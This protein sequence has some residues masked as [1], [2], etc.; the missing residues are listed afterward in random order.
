ML[1][2]KNPWVIIGVLT[3]VLFGGAI[4]LSQ[5]GSS[6]SNEGVERLQ[7]IAG[8]P[9]STIVL[10]E[11]SDLQCPACASFSPVVE[12]V[13]AQYGDA[14][15]FEYKQFPLPMHQYALQAGVAAEAA[16][17]QGKFFEFAEMLFENQQAWSTSRVPGTFFEQ[18]ATDLG[19]DIEQFKRQSQSTDLRDYVKDQMAEGR[20]REVSGTP[21]FFLNGTKMTYTTVEEFLNQIATAVSGTNTGTTTASSV[22]FGIN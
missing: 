5:Q 14:I 17:Q 1:H 15:R 20:D 16:A 21:T 6:Q 19:M 18:Y 9:D 12:Q 2:M 4:L 11:F 22:E 3:V 10:E 7:H 8:N 13:L